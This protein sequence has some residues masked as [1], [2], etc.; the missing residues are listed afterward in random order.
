MVLKRY[1]QDRAASENPCGVKSIG[2]NGE[3]RERVGLEKGVRKVCSGM[4]RVR[5]KSW[6]A[7]S[8]L[9]FL[10]TVSTYYLPSSGMADDHGRLNYPLPIFKS[11]LKL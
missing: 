9:T 3:G 8:Y 7:V 4:Y 6:I 10:E 1:V 11:F 5:S 2:L